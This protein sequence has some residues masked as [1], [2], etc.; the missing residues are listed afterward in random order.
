MEPM[1]EREMEPPKEP[2]MGQN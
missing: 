1:R 2:S